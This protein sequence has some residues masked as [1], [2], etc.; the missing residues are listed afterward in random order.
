MPFVAST[1]RL[2]PSDR[3]LAGYPFGALF[4]LHTLFRKPGLHNRPIGIDGYDHR[5]TDMEEASL[6]QTHCRSGFGSHREAT[7]PRG[8]PPEEHQDSVPAD[9]VS[10]P[11]SAA[12]YAATAEGLVE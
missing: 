12:K 6:P 2:N 11:S 3:T 4:V 1:Y 9:P 5:L 8:L 10:H 7:T